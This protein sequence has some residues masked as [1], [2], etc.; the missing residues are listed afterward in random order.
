M[1]KIF[2]NFAV[3]MTAALVVC[4]AIPVLACS[5]KESGIV[6][7]SA[8][9]IADINALEK[10]E[11]INN[12]INS[13]PKGEKDLRPIKLSPNMEKQSGDKCIFGMCLYQ[14]LLGE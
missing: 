10:S 12:E 13:M 6:S 11:K 9:S 3:V 14:N 8:C 5:N 1:K 7:G 4:F 2:Q